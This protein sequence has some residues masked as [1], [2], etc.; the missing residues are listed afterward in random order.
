VS[1]GHPS[2]E[3][4]QGLLAYGENHCQWS[5]DD[6]QVAAGAG[7]GEP[8]ESL[9]VTRS[10]SLNRLVRT[11]MPGGVGRAVRN[12]RP[13]M[14]PETVCID[15]TVNT[16]VVP[17]ERSEAGTTT[18]ADSRSTAL[19]SGDAEIVGKR[20]RR[21]LPGRSPNSR[22]SRLRDLM[23]SSYLQG[24]DTSK[25][26]FTCVIGI[27]VSKA[28]LD[29]ADRPDSRI[30]QFDNDASGHQQLLKTLPEPETCLV[31]LEATGRYEKSVVMELVNAGHLVSVVNPRQVRDFAKSLGILA[32]TDK[33][34]ARVISRFGELVR[35]RTVAQTHEKQDELDELTTRRRQLVAARTAE[36][37]RQAMTT[38]KVVSESVQQLIDHLRKDVRRIDDE[39]TRLV[40]SDDEWSGKSEL[41]QS[42]PGVGDVTASTLIAELPELGQLNRQ[43]I[44]ALVGVAP[45]NRDSGQFRGRRTIFGGRRAVRSVLYMA[46]L[47]ARRHNPVIR[48]FAD[49]LEAQGKRPKVI[50]VACMRKLLVIL[51]SMVKTNTPWNPKTI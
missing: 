34:D 16:V 30:Q 14:L 50:I 6:E 19:R 38:S 25:M 10:T 40:K 43:K 9:G 22:Q 39:I 51:N 29:V 32:K 47:T 18:V 23:S 17:A 48:T 4:P 11:R 15:E 13:C 1:S 12:G 49:R 7:T 44:S 27:D 24:R 41:L 46:A 33:I 35:P 2:R 37:N 20:D 36:M 28:R 45:F 3:E 8:E 5:R 42:T 31:V 21:R 26:D